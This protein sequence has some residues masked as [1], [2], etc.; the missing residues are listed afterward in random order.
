MNVA[1]GVNLN[2]EI[3]EIFRS[4]AMNRL[5]GTHAKVVSTRVTSQ[6]RTWTLLFRQTSK[7]EVKKQLL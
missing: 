7:N 2:V 1:L 6:L 3:G 5:G 4:M